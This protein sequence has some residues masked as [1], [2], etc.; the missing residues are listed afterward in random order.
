MDFKTLVE[1][2]Q[3]CRNFISKEVPME[4][5]VACVEAARL[6]PSA[7]NAQPMH[8]TLCTGS[9]AR[10]VAA[11]TQGMG[12]NR[13]TEQVPCFAV[14]KD[15]RYNFTASA[16]SK[17]KAQDY[18]SV[19]MGIAAAHFVLA[20]EERGLATCILGWFDEKKLQKLLGTRSRIR[21]VIALGYAAPDDPVRPKVRK[22]LREF[23]D[24]RQ[25]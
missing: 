21:L 13:F 17:V 16:G 9:L 15:E 20:A 2:R 6:A 24:F 11:C 3:S 22:D 4:D 10:Q 7:C 1:K 18:R 14:V 8:F 25:E 19:D 12:M 23:A 5:I